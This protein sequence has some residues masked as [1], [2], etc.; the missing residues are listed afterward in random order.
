LSGA[1]ISKRKKKKVQKR[2]KLP[3]EKSPSA[4][5]RRFSFRHRRAFQ[6]S[7][8]SIAGKSGKSC[9]CLTDKN[10]IKTRQQKREIKAQLK[11]QASD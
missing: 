7:E 1:L 10:E 8:S 4:H 2:V 3:I 5:L 11:R 6:V 9:R